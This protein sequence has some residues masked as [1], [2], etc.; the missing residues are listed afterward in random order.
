MPIET[1]DLTAGT[2]VATT[3][4][5]GTL[6]GGGTRKFLIGVGGAS[7]TGLV[8]YLVTIFLQLSGGTMTGPVV[9]DSGTFAGAATVTLNTATHLDWRQTDDLTDATTAITLSNCADGKAGK[10]SV[11]QDSDGNGVVTLAVTGATLIDKDDGDTADVDVDA[12]ADAVSHIFYDCSTVEGT[13]FATYTAGAAPAGSGN[14]TTS[15]TEIPIETDDTGDGYTVGDRVCSTAAGAC[16]IA[17]DVSTG[18]AVWRRDTSAIGNRSVYLIK[19][20]V[21]SS[22]TQV[23]LDGVATSGTIDTPAIA[24]SSFR[25]SLR[26]VNAFDTGGAV[27]DIR[28]MDIFWRGDS[29]G[30]GGFYAEWTWA[31]ASASSGQMSACG[32]YDGVGE[33][34]GFDPLG[35]TNFIAI[36]NGDA[37]TTLQIMSNDATSTGAK[38]SLGASYPSNSTTPVYRA[39]LYAPANASA[40]Y[41]V[42]D[43]VDT[44]TVSVRGSVSS[45]LPSNAA[46]L[47]F[48]CGMWD[49]SSDDA[50]FDLMHFYGEGQ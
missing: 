12:T 40:I 25:E 13:L 27:L 14:T 9:L 35:D 36:G 7:A 22:I 29:A 4:L 19:P 15:Q 18:A 11:R 16:W 41:Y 5:V 23:G 33:F 47:K 24:T 8:A 26:R 44:A 39:I 49:A 17:L 1:K 28:T 6:T 42:V 34:T 50:S 46:L 48:W 38:T 43:R 32:L 20:Y 3:S 37:D 10:I 30:E 31:I 21:S 45:N 2:P